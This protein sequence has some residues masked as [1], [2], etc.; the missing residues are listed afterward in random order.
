MSIGQSL[1]P[2]FDAE[3]SD[4]RKVLERVPDAHLE[5]QPH[6]KSMTLGRLATHLAELP[7]WTVMTL[8]QESV[9]LAPPDGEE[10]TP[11]VA[12]SRDEILSIFDEAAANARRALA[13]ASDDVF[14]ETWTLKRADQDVFSAPKGAVLRRFVMNHSVHHRGQLTVFLRLL[15]A[16]VP[17]TYGPSADEPNF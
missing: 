7:G 10:W 6:E 13:E 8:S 9:D 14:G 12:G 16:H 1:L 5:W 3:M 11:R 17:S 4:T 15:D 2:E